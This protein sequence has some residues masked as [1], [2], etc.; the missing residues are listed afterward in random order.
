MPRITKDTIF[1][2]SLAE[3]PGNTG[4]IMFNAAFAAKKMEYLYKA[5]GVK[6]KHLSAAIEGIR[7]IGV[8]GCGIS[9][10]YKMAAAK[11]VDSLDPAAQKIGA[12]NTIVNTNGRLKGYNTD[13]YG[14]ERLLGTV[15]GLHKK[16][17]VLLGAGGVARAI[18][19]ALHQLGARDVTL[20]NREYAA[21]QTLANQWRFSV[22]RWPAHQTLAADLFINATPIGMA[23]QA[24]QSP[25][26]PAAL[27][28]YH[29]IMD[30]VTN[31]AT[32]KLMT[33]ARQRGKRV[34][35]G[36]D[37][38]LQQALRQFELYTGQTPPAAVMQKHLFALTK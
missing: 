26:R 14:A 24:T 7:V 6:P 34:L 33:M 9:M 30:V 35:R 11:L 2:M 13:A 23:P 31:P 37:M 12:I 27:D 5:F 36:L 19:Y 3:R 15:H 20:V 16:T 17:I 10:P 21:A 1:C 32:T 25:L 28:H 18:C 8:R 22:A 29:L 4:T 38:T